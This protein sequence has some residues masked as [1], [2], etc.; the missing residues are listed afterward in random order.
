MRW[1]AEQRE[2]AVRRTGYSWSG[3]VS[4]AKRA[5]IASMREVTHEQLTELVR[6]HLEPVARPAPT[7]VL[8][9]LGRVRRSS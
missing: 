1:D 2:I 6:A 4:L 5:G 3:L 8:D 9:V 7:S